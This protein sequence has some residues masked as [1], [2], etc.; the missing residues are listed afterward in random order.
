MSSTNENIGDLLNAQGISWGWFQGGLPPSVRYGF[1]QGSVQHHHEPSRRHT[2]N[3]LQRLPQ[4][5]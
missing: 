4:S 2:G 3:S 5:F 1:G